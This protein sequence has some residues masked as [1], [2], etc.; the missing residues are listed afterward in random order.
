MPEPVTPDCDAVVIGTGP[1]GATAADVLTGAGWSVIM[2]EKGSNHLL[3]L[4][5]PF[6]P[7]GHVSNDEIK[8]FR[9]HFLGPDPFLEPRTF[10]R[11]DADGDH[12]FAGEVNNLPSTV[13]GGGFHADAKLPRFRAVDFKARSEL[14]PIEGCRHRRLARRL[15]R[16]RALLRARR[17]ARRRGR[18][19]GREPVRRVAIGRLPDAAGRRHV[20]LD[21]HNRSR[22]PAR[23][24]PL[25]R[26]RPA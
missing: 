18:P 10:R 11:D 16:D 15:R 3:A 6:D 22:D 7:L 1:A 19:R 24:P 21:P 8:F 25:R 4:D 13:G 26:R 2:L 20:R 9:R 17:T 5:A 12:V 23:L 14:G